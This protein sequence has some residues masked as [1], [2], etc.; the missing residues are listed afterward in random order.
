M[1][2]SLCPVETLYVGQRSRAVV[3]CSVRGRVT[4]RLLAAAFTD[5]LAR[6][7]PL[8]CAIAA[9]G[10]G[11][12]LRELDPPPRLETYRAADRGYDDELNTP[13]PVGGPLIRAALL[14]GGTDR[15]GVDTLV[16]SIDHTITDGQ[17][18]IA[19]HNALWARYRTLLDT[20]DAA[21]EPYGTAWPAPV[22]EL[23]PPCSDDEVGRYFDAR[24]RAA[25]ARPVDLL[26]HDAAPSAGGGRIEVA[27]LLLGAEDTAGLRRAAQAARVSVHG[28]IAAALLTTARRRLGGDGPRT[29]GCLSPV[30]LRSRLTPPLARELMVAAVTFHSEALDVAPDSDPLRL[31]RQVSGGLSRA[32]LASEPFT[33]MRS[34]PRA[35]RF[36]AL[37]LGTVIA[38]NMGAVSGPRLPAGLDLLDLRL[39]PAREHYFPQ[40]GRSP[41]MACATTFDGRLAVE[42]PYWTECFTPSAMSAF[43]DGVRAALLDRTATG[44]PSVTTAP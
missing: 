14:R 27:R 41:V 2:R 15:D 32:I 20:P 25:R 22:S 42:F 44:P 33:Q 37:M 6:H 35:E 9:E 39:V 31:A 21:P 28:L 40:A 34:M 29:L 24:V 16:V 13:L 23:L 10:S 19:L 5:L 17:S 11:H 7:P 36:P 4:P 18:A 12:V 1:Q 8:R 3:S 30:D 43:R 38:T 26:P